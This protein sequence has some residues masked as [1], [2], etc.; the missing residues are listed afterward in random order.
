MLLKLL[1]TKML[2][3]YWLSEMRAEESVFL[4]KEMQVEWDR[5]GF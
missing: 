1:G 4:L 3:F 2:D 5:E